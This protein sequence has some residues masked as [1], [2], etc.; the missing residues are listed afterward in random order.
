MVWLLITGC[1]LACCYFLWRWRIDPL[2]IGF[3]STLVYFHPVFWPEIPTPHPSLEFVAAPVAPETQAIM[4]IV[5]VALTF[6]AALQ[7]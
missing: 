3:G 7:D 5:V 2:A 4:L 6:A 1:A